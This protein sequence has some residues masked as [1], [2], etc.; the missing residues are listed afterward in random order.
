M[1]SDCYKLSYN[2]AALCRKPCLLHTWMVQGATKRPEFVWSAGCRWFYLLRVGKSTVIG[3]HGS[4]QVIARGS[5]MAW[6]RLTEPPSS[7][8][9]SRAWGKLDHDRKL[10]VIQALGPSLHY[11][12]SPTVRSSHGR[13]HCQVAILMP[14]LWQKQ[15]PKVILPLQPPKRGERATTVVSLSCLGIISIKSSENHQMA[16]PF[17][18]V[19]RTNYNVFF[20]LM[21]WHKPLVA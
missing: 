14:E 9:T 12:T 16:P 5:L 17:C 2:A 11:Y 20:N 15:H 7:D 4:E 10:A 18:H 13:R 21:S 6:D 1:H 3:W 8:G 19:C